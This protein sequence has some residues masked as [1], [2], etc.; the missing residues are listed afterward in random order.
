M[1]HKPIAWILRA[2]MAL[3]AIA[4]VGLVSVAA[5][6]SQGPID[7]SYFKPRVEAALDR[8]LEG[9]RAELG[10]LTLEMRDGRAALAG[11]ELS[12]LGPNGQVIARADAVDVGLDVPSLLKGEIWPSWLEV[13]GARVIAVRNENGALSVLTNTR[14]GADETQFDI[15]DALKRWISGEART[16]A[17]PDIRLIDA[18]LVVLDSLQGD[19][20]WTGRANAGAEITP[21]AAQLWA[22]IGYADALEAAPVRFS[23][24]L[25]RSKGGQARVE[26][27]DSDLSILARV[28]RIFGASLPPADGL[29]SGEANVLIDE[30]FAATSISTKLAGK[31]VEVSLAGNQRYSANAFSLDAAADVPA[32]RL[33][34]R[35]LRLGAADQVIAAGA[36]APVDLED[37]SKGY[38]IGARIDKADAGYLAGIL[39]QE[40]AFAGVSG[41]VSADVDAVVSANGLHRVEMHVAAN[42]TIDNPDLLHAKISIA[43]ASAFF[44]FDGAERSLTASGIAMKAHDIPVEAAAKL[45]F[46]PAFELETLAATARLGG[47]PATRLPDIWP[48]AFS[49]GGRAWVAR[50]ILEGRIDGAEF[51][52]TK[53]PDGPITAEGNFRG[54]GLTVRYWDPMPVATGVSGV[55]RFEGDVLRIDVDN[56]ASAGMTTDDIKLVFT[57]LGQPTEFLSLDGAIRGPV[58][59]L[60][61]VLDRKPLEYAKWLGVDPKTTSGSVDGR[62]KMS[63]PLIDL[64]AVDDLKIAAEGAVKDATLPGVV[65]GWDLAAREMRIDV[66]TRRLAAKGDGALLGQPI[67]FD[68]DLQFGRGPELA[69]FAGEWRLTRDVRREI[70]LGGPAF[71]RRL[72]GAMPTKFQ[73]IARPRALYEISVDSD[74]RDATLLAQEI[75]WLKPKGAPGRLT[76]TAVIQ[77]ELPVRV[78][79]IKLRAEDFSVDADVAF[80]PGSDALQRVDVRRLRGAGHDLAARVTFGESEDTVEIYGRDA[81]LRPLLDLEPAPASASETEQPPSRPK[82]FA[83][84]LSRA[85]ISEKF[86]LGDV[87]ATFRLADEWPASLNGTAAYAGGRIAVQ[88]AEPGATLQAQVSD[89]GA[90]V[91]ATGALNG[92]EGGAANFDLKRQPDGGAALELL[93]GPFHIRKAEIARLSNGGANGLLGILGDSDTVKFDHLKLF[94]GYDEGVLTIDKGRAVGNALGVTSAGAIDFRR[95][96][97]DVSGAIS[98]AFAVSRALGAIPILGELLTGSRKEGVFAANYRLSGLLQD[99]EVKIDGLSALAPG[100]LREVLPK[101]GASTVEAPGERDDP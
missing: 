36:A 15:F 56:G 72:T 93:T 47:L 23:A 70:G 55:G 4:V 40:A 62:I 1:R 28:G 32:R 52:L 80:R 11:A 68:G 60:L 85:R 10:A 88:E 7:L 74:L 92:I 64:L 44:A 27:A 3:A 94:G 17:L 2:V 65:N 50:N 20:L 51:E 37:L 24:N 13:R 48:K 101:P 89:F 8:T 67:T 45:V 69:R 26:F 83:I 46:D 78:D 73:V 57:K 5:A 9:V 98:P 38:R 77:N 53:S 99:P 84:D 19:E 18:E 79:D 16:D 22:V 43:D 75:G 59:R 14:A 34:I 86:A 63:F 30:R 97:I 21:E 29:V 96:L 58:D 61:E 100:I 81:D 12:A 31:D 66:D 90:F 35:G 39:G 82:R 91:A 49:K 33:T 71:R 76:A 6:L 25:A 42:A 95:G 41:A 54:S 87:R